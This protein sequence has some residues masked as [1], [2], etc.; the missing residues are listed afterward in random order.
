M[1]VRHLWDALK[2]MHHHVI[3]VLI[4]TEPQSVLAAPADHREVRSPSRPSRVTCLPSAFAPREGVHLA[5]AELMLGMAF[6]WIM[7]RPNQLSID[8]LKI[9]RKM[10][11]RS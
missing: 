3:C 2:T 10:L 7:I 9:I 11:S 1:H 5:R 4:L 6:V 8:I